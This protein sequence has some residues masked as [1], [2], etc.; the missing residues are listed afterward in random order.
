MNYEL[1]LFSNLIRQSLHPSADTAD[2]TPER[3][4]AFGAMI[5]LESNRIRQQLNAVVCS[6]RSESK[7]RRYIRQHQREILFLA[8]EVFE[9]RKSL[10]LNGHAALASLYT[11]L[12]E[13]LTALRQFMH[14]HFIEYYDVDMALPQTCRAAMVAGELKKLRSLFNLLKER[15]IDEELF[16][17]LRVFLLQQIRRKNMSHTEMDYLKE[18]NRRLSGALSGTKEI[19]WNTK[20]LQELLYLDFNDLDFYI[21]AKRWVRQQVIKE[22]DLNGQLNKLAAFHAFV[23]EFQPHGGLAYHPGRAS[24]KAQTEGF[25][26][27]ETELLELQSYLPLNGDHEEETYRLKVGFSVPQLAYFVKLLVRAGM[28]MINPRKPG[29]LLDFLSAYLVT[30]KTGKRMSSE[31]FKNEYHAK[32]RTAAI[33]VK[34][35][36]IKLLN[37]ANIDLNTYL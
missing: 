19:D 2:L 28:F 22:D 3:I 34:A 29:L 7:V 18:V 5:E 11:Y 13:K 33:A 26:R 27:S 35:I 15:N 4:L 37:M 30:G 9:T 24:L 12:L 17:P 1:G 8:D 10:A 6:D 14:Q 32:N 20:L 25:L 36:L 16:L 31:N 23:K 21:A